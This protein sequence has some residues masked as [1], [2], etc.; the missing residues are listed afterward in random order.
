MFSDTEGSTVLTE[1]LGYE[2]WLKLLHNHNAVI[3]H[4]LTVH[5]SFAVTSQG[6]G[7][8]AAF[9]SASSAV[10]CAIVIQ[11]DFAERRDRT[12]SRLPHV[13]IGLH[14]GEVIREQEDFFVHNVIFAAR[15]A[16]KAKNDKI[17]VS[18]VLRKLIAGNQEFQFGD[19]HEERRKRLQDPQ[20]VHKVWWR[21]PARR[22]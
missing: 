16:V 3:R 17:L 5:R 20:Q 10:R 1:Q 12:G 19:A 7:S 13:W 9:G 6:D 18:S 14:A 15:I 22:G 2:R 21:P 11:H 8:R 4:H